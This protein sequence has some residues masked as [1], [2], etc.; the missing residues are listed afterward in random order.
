MWKLKK[1]R[2]IKIRGRG[3][4]TACGEDSMSNKEEIKKGLGFTETNR[5]LI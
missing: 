1:R 5:Q 2:L 3:I 4:D